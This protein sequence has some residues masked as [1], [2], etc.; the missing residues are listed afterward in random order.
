[1]EVE[2]NDDDDEGDT[3]FCLLVDICFSYLCDSDRFFAFVD[4][5]IML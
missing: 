2:Y 1:M 5:L 3:T 4:F